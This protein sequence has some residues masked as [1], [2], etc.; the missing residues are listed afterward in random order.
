MIKF[1]P[2]LIKLT[3]LLIDHATESLANSMYK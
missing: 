3:I 1:Y 2:S